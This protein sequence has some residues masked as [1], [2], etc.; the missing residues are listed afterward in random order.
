VLDVTFSKAIGSRFTLKG[1]ITDILNQTNVLLQ[2]GNQDKK[3]DRQND[4]LI[5]TYR[6][7]QTIQLGFSYRIK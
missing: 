7:G 1:G 5:Q 3:F 6:P 4:Q 2:D